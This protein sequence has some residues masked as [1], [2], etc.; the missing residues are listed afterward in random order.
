MSET[1]EDPARKRTYGTV[2]TAD[3][4]SIEYRSATASS[5]HVAVNGV[6][7]QLRA[8]QVLGII[9]ESGSGKSTLAMALAG[10][11]DVRP[12][13]EGAPQ[14]CG[15]SL[16]VLGTPMRRLGKKARRVL[17]L[18]VG[19]LPQDAAQRLNPGLTVAE[20]V[21]EPIFLRDRR[22]DQ[23]EAGKLVATL[24][25]AVHLPLSALGLMTYELSSGQLQR[26][27]LARSLILDPELL[28]AD[29]PIRGV[30]ILVRHHVL[31][32]I[33]ELQAAR[34]FSAVVVS[35]DLSVVQDVAQRIAVLQDG[36]IIGLG[37][38]DE[39]VTAPEHPYLKGLSRALASER[40][41]R[42]DEA[43]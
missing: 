38:L 32:V 13:D 24:I 14:I 3:D 22:F 33:P 29:E 2:I 12:V 27:A 26:V 7:L 11:A 34:G 4:L 18:R 28:V 20:N 43:R 6:T 9:G 35:S 41:P 25:D 36:V 42:E 17:T 19:Y 15:G 10:L 1:H 30:D 16:T 23:N 37:T 5:R 8:G 39:L 40:Q 21:A 31:N